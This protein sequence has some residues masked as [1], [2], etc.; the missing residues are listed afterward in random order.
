[1]SCDCQCS[2]PLPHVAM[3]WSTGLRCVIAVFPHHT[4]LL[5]N[6][7]VSIKCPDK[8]LKKKVTFFSVEGT[9]SRF[10]PRSTVN[11][12]M[13]A[14]ILFSRIAQ[15]DIFGTFKFATRT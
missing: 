9:T 13:F 5:F 11:L 3:G 2:V 15:N 6:K 7:G 10:V 4:Y 14:R 8:S 1:M 12:E